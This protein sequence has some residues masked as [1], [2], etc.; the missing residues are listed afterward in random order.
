MTEEE[1]IFAGLIF[2]P[3]KKELKEI[4][5]KAHEA[6]RRYNALDEYD[7][8]R[9]EIIREI[10]GGI[11]EPFISRDRFSSITEAMPISV[12]IFLPTLT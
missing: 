3:R 1:K 5:H 11:G 7:P 9:Q 2:D 6:C 8:R 10:I 4:K 12:I